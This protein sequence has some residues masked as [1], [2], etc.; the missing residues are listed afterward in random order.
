MSVEDTHFVWALSDVC[1]GHHAFTPPQATSVA[2]GARKS[3][4]IRQPG[5]ATGPWSPEETP[6]MVEP[7]NMLASRRHEAVAFAGPARTGKTMGML[8]GW[9][10]HT[11]VNDPGD[12]LFIQMTQDKAREFSK[13]DVR[14]AIDYSPH[15]ASMLSKNAAD[16]NT[17]DIMF[18]NGMWVRIAWPTVSNVSGSTYRYV[19]ITD[20]D[21]IPNAENVDGEGPLFSLALKRTTTFLSRGMCLAES[22]PGIEVADP[23][24]KPATPHE[25]PPVTGILGIYN[26]SDRRRWYWQCPHC[27]DHFEAAP[28]L[29]LFNLPP[30]DHLIEVIRTLDMQAEAKRYGSRIVCPC[31]GAEIPKTAKQS[32]NAKG[33]WLADGQQITP[34]GEIV[35]PQPSSRIAGYW[36]G[37]VAA[38]YQSW[39]S[40]V[41]RY[42]LGLRDYAL[43]GSEETLKA[44]INTDQGMPYTS[45]HLMESAARASNPLER[46]VQGM[47]RHVVPDW[48]RCVV[49]AVDVQGG[50]NARFE[51][52]VHAVGPDMEQQLVDR[53]AITKSKREG[54]GQEFAPIDPGAYPEDWDILTERLLRATWRTSTPGLEIKLSRL[55]VDS[56]GEDG[57]TMNAYAWWRRLRREGLAHKTR[58]YKG[59]SEPKA[60]LIKE[61]WVGK[62]KTTDKP[63]VP[64]LVC[65]PHL[66]SDAVDAGLK[67]G[68]P[69]ANYIHFPA[70]KHPTQNPD[71]WLPAAFFDEL[72]AEIRNA[73]GRWEKIR[74]R[75]ESFDLCRMIRA[76]ILHMGLEKV[77]DWSVVPAH[78]APL[79][80]N[81]EVI[82][83]EDRRE[84][85][86]NERVE[87]AAPTPAPVRIV[88]PKRSRT[89]RSIPS[90]YLG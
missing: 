40:L 14:R 81:S 48:T 77:R 75:N 46:A 65:N 41:L 11:V 35:G 90:P 43:T 62:R 3:L 18:R 10:A 63:D 38:A 28:G 9:M 34:A 70:P 85:Q 2:E 32:M 49:A 31:C 8:L 37:G 5:A 21:R 68:K 19:A 58:L 16:R 52:Q 55:V 88:Q 25:A 26:R 53:F 50:S 44:T 64:L 54:I 80:Q 76:G 6:Y 30:D 56:G 67:R 86:E 24:W 15:V 78:L 12:M 82:T 29:S 60:Q 13:T 74:K 1:S 17:H 84:M 79:G 22:S 27:E 89:R 61:T 73:G 20:L 59:A 51:V 87:N 47:E 33:V 57:V 69:G 7:M 66:L 71:G 36:L 45:R 23:K 83:R 42:L 72:S 39:E 4:V